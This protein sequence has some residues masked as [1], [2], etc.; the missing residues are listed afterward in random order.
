MA[1]REKELGGRECSAI[2]GKP[3]ILMVS[4]ALQ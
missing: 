4:E 1:E 3:P 2:A